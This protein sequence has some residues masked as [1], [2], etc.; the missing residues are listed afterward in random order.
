VD[1][2]MSM[3]PALEGSRNGEEPPRPLDL[4]SRD[5]L[6]S[7]RCD[8]M[9]QSGPQNYSASVAV[10]QSMRCMSW[11]DRGPTD[12]KVGYRSSAVNHI[13]VGLSNASAALILFAFT[14]SIIPFVTVS[15]R[16]PSTLAQFPLSTWMHINPLAIKPLSNSG[17][18][19][20]P[21]RPLRLLTRSKCTHDYWSCQRDPA[22]IAGHLLWTI[23]SR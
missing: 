12:L 1:V 17:R 2:E 16:W 13:S 21:P 9:A 8:D 20:L 4:G 22:W 5:H 19:G 10:S 15:A 18:H 7:E 6:T 3:L 23:M 14:R 11:W